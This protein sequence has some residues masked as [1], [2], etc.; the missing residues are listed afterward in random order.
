[1]DEPPPKDNP[2]DKPGGPPV[3]PPARLAAGYL[4]DKIQDAEG[5]LGYLAVSGISVDGAVRAA[6][7]EART[8][9]DAG[10]LTEE[11]AARFLAALTVLAERASPVTAAHLREVALASNRAYRADE[12][13]RKIVLFYGIAAAFVGGL[14]ILISLATYF[15]SSVSDKI[16]AD[17]DTANGLASKLRSELGPS[18]SVAPAV[19]EPP[20]GTGMAQADKVWYGTDTPPPG[21]SDRDVISDLQQFA[22]T[23]REI[24]GYTK[25]LRY[26]VLDF[27]DQKYAKKDANSLELDAGLD[28]RLSEE[29]TKK[30]EEYQHVRN[31]GNDLQQKVTAYYGAMATCILP[32]LY[33]LLGAAAYLLRQTEAQPT[34]RTLDPRSLHIARFVIAGIGGLVVGLFN[35]FVSQGITFSPFALAFLVGYAAD[36]FFTFLEG[37]MQSFKRDPATDSAPAKPSDP[38]G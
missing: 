12:R 5:L 21:L 2:P 4:L 10:K 11:I 17:I 16:R 23:M 37:L 1:M 27:D 35:N 14:I 34:K 36:V 15:S 24:H 32:V 28:L 30:V 22:A 3:S 9:D 18:P 20:P 38:Q 33:S 7:L 29:L 13:K 6:V 8:A 26:F 31:L 19:V 25:Q